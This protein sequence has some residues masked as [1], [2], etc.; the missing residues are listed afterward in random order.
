[1]AQLLEEIEKLSQNICDRCERPWEEAMAKCVAAQ[2]ER[3]DLGAKLKELDGLKPEIARL[4]KEYTAVGEFVPSPAI[5]E[6]RDIT[7]T[8]A[9]Q[10]AEEN[11]RIQGEMKLLTVEQGQKIA[12]AQKALAEAQSSL[13]HRIEAARADAYEKLQ[14]TQE[15]LETLERDQQMADAHV[16]GIQASLSRVQI[17]NARAAQIQETIAGM[18]SDLK[19][20]EEAVAK[21]RAELNAELDF[22]K[23]IGREGF[24]GA[25]FD[26]VLWEISEE[27]NRL[28]AQFPNTAHVTLYFRS[29]ATSQK[30]TI[31]KSITPVVSIGGFEAA[32]SSGLSGGMETAVELAVDLAV[33]EVVSRR[34]GAVPGWL[35]LDESFTGLGP[36]E[37]EASMEILRAFAENKLVLVVDHASEFKS[38]FT[39]SI[40]VEYQAGFSRVVE[41]K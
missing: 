7:S 9:A 5:Q 23:L 22:Q 11:A 36:V 3:T 26:E 24:L 28:L 10:C 35:I 18:E 31:K 17:D 41:S 20:S 33:A 30:G 40:E 2:A 4:Q 25:I 19:A 39:Q 14:G 12:Q 38:M 13:A 37:A 15:E 16:K 32:L 8:L 29:E 34:T 27:T 1:M 6:L 21:L